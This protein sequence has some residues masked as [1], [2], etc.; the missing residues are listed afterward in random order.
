M[1]Y[2][3]EFAKIHHACFTLF[4]R[5]KAAPRKIPTPPAPTDPWA[6]VR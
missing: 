1:N 4:G 6:A 2:H 5:D 3:G